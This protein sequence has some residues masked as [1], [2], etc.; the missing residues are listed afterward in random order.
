MDNKGGRYFGVELFKRIFEK[1]PDAMDLL[2]IKDKTNLYTNRD[3]CIHSEMISK[4]I[5][6]IV[7]LLNNTDQV[8]VILKS[9]GQDHVYR[10]IKPHH[11]PVTG[12]AM[13]ETL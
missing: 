13:L 5:T 3:F 6:Q 11:Y 1:C 2:S 12:E 7:N 8:V 9:L 10:G 4:K